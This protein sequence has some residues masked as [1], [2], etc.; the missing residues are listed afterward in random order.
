MEMCYTLKVKPGRQNI[1]KG[2]VCISQAIGNTLTIQDKS[3]KPAFLI[4]GYGAQRLELK[5]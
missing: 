2:L 5:G 1:E 4:T 3:A